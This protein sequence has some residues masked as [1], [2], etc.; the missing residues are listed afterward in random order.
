MKEKCEK[1]FKILK[2]IN[3]ITLIVFLAISLFIVL[4]SIL[5]KAELYIILLFA[6]FIIILN[7]FMIVEY[8]KFKKSAYY[9]ELYGDKV[10]F[11]TTYKQIEK[12][13]SECKR[14]I[15]LAWFSCFI[16]NDETI[17]LNKFIGC[18]QVFDCI[19]K[20]TFPNI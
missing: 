15:H 1:S 14:I 4:V 18:S 6:L 19:S 5:M 16:F 12:R 2:I 10:V 11:Y 17:R 8:I 20:T 9:I 3:I 13:A 7:F